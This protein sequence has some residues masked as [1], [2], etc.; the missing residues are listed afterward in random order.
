MSGLTPLQAK[1]LE[2]ARKRLFSFD[3][4]IP[5]DMDSVP[6]HKQIESYG[7]DWAV[8]VIVSSASTDVDNR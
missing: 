4:Y 2:E 6:L 5:V 8:K 3:D 1:A 7:I